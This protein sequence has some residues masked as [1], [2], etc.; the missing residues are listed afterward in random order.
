MVCVIWEVLRSF[1]RL[2][3]ESIN[4]FASSLFVPTLADIYIDG[5]RGPEREKKKPSL[6][7]LDAVGLGFQ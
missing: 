4:V 5:A 2:L 6:S 1:D 3:A 7:G